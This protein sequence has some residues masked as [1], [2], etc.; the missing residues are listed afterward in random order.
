M[1]DQEKRADAKIQIWNLLVTGMIAIIGGALGAILTFYLTQTSWVIST[2]FQQRSALLQKRLDLI[3]RTAQLAGK[4][5][6][7]EDVWQA[8][9]KEI[10]TSVKKGDPLPSHDPAL[11]EK[12]AEY[13]GQFRAILE[14]DTLF[15]GPKTRAELASLK[16]KTDPLPYWEYPADNMSHLLAAMANELQAPPVGQTATK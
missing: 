9:L 10:G 3:E 11:S 7:M 12:L 4:A 16:G 1:T 5:P 13:N 2:D 6:G 14:L 15:F 8:Y